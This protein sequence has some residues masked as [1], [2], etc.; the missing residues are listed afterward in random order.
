MPFSQLRSPY[1]KAPASQCFESLIKEHICSRSHVLEGKY[2]GG[3]GKEIE[4]SFDLDAFEKE[5]MYTTPK[6]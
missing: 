5:I 2:D 4:S 1:F 3:R 6:I